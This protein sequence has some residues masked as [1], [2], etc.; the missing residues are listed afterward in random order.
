MKRQVV[1]ATG[2]PGKLR[3]VT[4]LLE[5]TGIEVVAQ[6]ALK[7]LAVE[8]T[9]DTFLANALQKARNAAQQ[10]RMPA[11]ADDSGLMVDA[12]AGL[13]GVHSARYA[14]VQATDE[15][16]IDKLLAALRDAPNRAAHF[17]CA[18][19]FVRD[20]EDV[21]PLVAAGRWSGRI[22]ACRQGSGGFGY[23]PVFF[24]P[25]LGRTSA[26]LT[27]EEKNARS[28]RGQ[29]IRALCR[30]ILSQWNELDGAP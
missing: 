29:A 1:M 18:A 24:D 9:G 15:Q 16:N 13:P 23:D 28:H 2:N 14:G 6:A 5:G 7:V 17:H 20:A 25:E 12:L 8:E 27:A 30:L 22:N 11:I 10:T 19:V 26:E 4:R 3:E 21:R